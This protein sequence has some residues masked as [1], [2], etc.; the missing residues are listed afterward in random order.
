MIDVLNNP[1]QIGEMFTSLST[2]HHLLTIKIVLKPQLTVW[3]Q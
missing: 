2:V 1:P 3:F